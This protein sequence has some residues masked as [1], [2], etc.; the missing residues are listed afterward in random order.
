MGSTAAT[1]RAGIREAASTSIAIAAKRTTSGSSGLTKPPA[2]RLSVVPVEEMRHPLR[3]S[4]RPGVP[5]LICIHKEVCNAIVQILPVVSDRSPLSL[6]SVSR[7][8][9]R[10]GLLRIVATF[11]RSSSFPAMDLPQIVKW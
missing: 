4:L 10:A 6:R 1:L 7:T 11:S 9:G 3:A 5:G 8:C 2:S